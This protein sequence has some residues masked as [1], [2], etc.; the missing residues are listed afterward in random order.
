MVDGA[1]SILIPSCTEGDFFIKICGFLFLNSRM[2]GILKISFNLS[3][4]IA[5][6]KLNED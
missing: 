4:A 3:V 5:I 1:D 6:V 2:Y